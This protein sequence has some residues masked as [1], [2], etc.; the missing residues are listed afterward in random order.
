MRSVK[1][2]P[3]LLSLFFLSIPLAHSAISVDSNFEGTL[4]L[5]TPE[6]EIN[7]YEPGDPLPEIQPGSIIE[8]FDGSF[9]LTAG[10]G[11]QVQLAC[12]E[13]DISS[14]GGSMRL[15]CGE[16]TGT[17]TV[18]KGSATVTSPDG[19]QASINEGDTYDINIEVVE[20]AEATA[21][22]E[23]LGLEADADLPDIDPTSIDINDN[24][25]TPPSPSA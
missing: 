23:A 3:V 16:T 4:V 19:E 13:H 25:D 10:T 9:S 8:V 24:Q 2:L 22:G 20:E 11:D 1:G 21:E 7:L 18:V 6:G 17:L 5:T 15:A 14:Q 12:L